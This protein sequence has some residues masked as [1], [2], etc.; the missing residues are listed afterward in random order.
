MFGATI[1][2]EVE[3]IS[4]AVEVS[5]EET[6]IPILGSDDEWAKTLSEIE[7]DNKENEG[8]CSGII[9]NCEY[10]VLD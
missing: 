7:A 3:E 8:I 4:G 9:N 1:S 10:L 5:E 2:A 6:E